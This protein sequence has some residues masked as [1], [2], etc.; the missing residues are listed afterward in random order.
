MNEKDKQA[1][2]EQYHQEKEK[3]L[4]F[5]PDIIFKDTIVILVV[6]LILVA[7]AYFVGA[8]L[9][10]RANPADSTYTPRPEWYFLFLFQLLKYFPGQLEVIGVVV[11]PTLVILLLFA[12]PFL[13]RS[14]KRYFTKRP[15]V[16]GI[17]F[18]GVAGMVFLTVQSIRETPPP[19]ETTGGDET[20]AL[21][22]KNCAACHGPSVQVSP[23]TDLHNVIA[24]GKHQGMP[25]WSADLTSDQID[26]LAGFILSPGGSQLFTTNCGSCHQVSQLVA[27]D[28]AKIKSAL[29]DGKNFPPHK[30]L[31]IPDW[32]TTLSSDEQT[33]ILNFLS[34][35]DGQR[36]FAINCSPCHGQFVSYSGDKSQLTALISQGGMH[37]D[38][39]S[40]REKLSSAD[41]ALLAKFV[42][43]PAS[44]P[45]AQKLFKANC[46]VCHG[47]RIPKVDTVEQATQII[48][49]GGS[50]QTM[51]IW[52]KVLTTQQIDALVNYTMAAEQGSSLVTG[53]NLFESNCAAC[54]GQHGEGGPNPSHPSSIIPPI[55]T[56][57]FLK[58]R[59]D[60]TLSAIISLGQPDLGMSSFGNANGGP[61]SDDDINNIVA[62]IRS[63]EANPP[64]EGVL[65]TEAPAQTLSLQGA[66]IYNEL[67][68]QCHG[69]DGAGGVG[70]S[71]S[72]PDFQAKNTDQ[73]I[74]DTI[75]KGHNSSAMIAW[76]KILTPGQITELVTF[77]RQL[78]SAQSQPVET[79]AASG[80]PSF[81]AD[82]MPLIQTKCGMCH[83]AAGGWDTS[84]YDTILHSGD[85][86]PVVIP[87]D[88]ANSLLA[89]KI[90][91]AQT[92]GTSM[93]PAG[94]MSAENIQI[95]LDWIKAGASSK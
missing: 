67:C 85:H 65:P 24:Q 55:S 71:L 37:K 36:L 92:E 83:G 66:G 46:S 6:F 40:W 11:I 13:D 87:G 72:S 50:H 64:V 49:S 68:A 73:D 60:T 75:N 82:V 4:P 25:A 58:T 84:S 5:F 44:S 39:P 80:P 7:L 52:G 62:Y 56:S 53:Q 27:S 2:L 42:V 1:Y 9:E 30:D 77:I 28:P 19:A 18:L 78:K 43:A 22:V 86:G 93:P 21:Y 16:T 29:V 51:P 20:A 88:V 34:A 91:G 12:L 79:Q 45:D 8:P 10:A 95:I 31:N 89:Q 57:E 70:P 90:T 94:K 54:H 81:T 76:G 63:W 32:S 59:D 3:G 48:A 35:P 23:G 17:T 41:L 26:A 38:M 74:I 33:K 61:L 47:D 15:L 14:P 69:S